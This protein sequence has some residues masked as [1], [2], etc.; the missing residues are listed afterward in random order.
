MKKQNGIR[1]P[2]LAEVEI[3]YHKRDIRRLKKKYK[4]GQIL[5]IITVRS[6]GVEAAVKQRR[7]M[8]VVKAFPNH[9]SCK[10]EYGQRESFGY[11][12]LEQIV[13]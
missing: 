3:I 12:E 2:Y 9:L 6:D 13:V 10:D 7:R 11:I 1:G 4:P 5:D 8:T